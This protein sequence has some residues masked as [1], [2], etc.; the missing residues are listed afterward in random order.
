MAAIYALYAR[1]VHHFLLGLTAGDRSEAEDIL[2]ET[3]LRAWRAIDSIPADDSGARRWLF[4]VARH[5]AV[6]AYRRRRTR[7]RE[8]SLDDVIG[9]AGRDETMETALTVQTIRE[10]VKRLTAAERAILADLYVHGRSQRQ[11]AALHGIPL[12]T[13]KS[14]SH[15]A[16]QALRRASLTGGDDKD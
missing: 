15:H 7:P 11:V 3:M 8:V 10:A 16:V 9:L 2:Q 5:A 1:P 14:R 4:T 12:G 13:V 6:D